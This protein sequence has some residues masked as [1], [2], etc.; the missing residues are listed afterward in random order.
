MYHIRYRPKFLADFVGNSAIIED[1]QR[2][3]PNWPKTFLIHGASGCG[4]TTL[5]RIIANELQCADMYIKEIDAAQDRGIDAMRELIKSSYARP[6]IGTMKVYIL[7]E[8]HMLT[9]ESMNALLKITEEPP[10]KTYFIFCSTNP[11][12]IIPTLTNRCYKINL[13]PLQDKEIGQI[14]KRVLDSEKIELTETLRKICNFILKE[15]KGI[16]REALILLSALKDCPTVEE[17]QVKLHGFTSEDPKVYELVQAIVKG[18]YVKIMSTFEELP[19][20]NYESLRIVIAKI[21]KKFI[22]NSKIEEKKILH[23]K[24]E[25]FSN[26]VDNHI[27]DIAL[28]TILW[29]CSNLYE[30]L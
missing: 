8:A 5:A 27:G 28:Y 17:A 29:K 23:K 18:D 15:S 1:L 20:S 6:L 22:K 19:Q 12:K 30:G 13:Q 11:T 26:S 4:K 21:L 10:P 3:Y 25:M 24:L 7:D 14:I 16:P 2:K 9:N